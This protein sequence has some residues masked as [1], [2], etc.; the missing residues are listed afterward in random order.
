MNKKVIIKTEERSQFESDI[1]APNLDSLCIVFVHDSVA[2]NVGLVHSRVL[3]H[4]E[5]L[6]DADCPHARER[7]GLGFS[8]AELIVLEDR[9]CA[10]QGHG[11]FFVEVFAALCTILVLVEYYF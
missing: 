7:I 4:H 11:R 2:E 9:D 1:V 8:A 10:E 6:C 3:V 5:L